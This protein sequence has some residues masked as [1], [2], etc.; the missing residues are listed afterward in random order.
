MRIETHY[1]ISLSL[2]YRTR[3]SKTKLRISVI[4]SSRTLPR[5]LALL[6]RLS[7]N[8]TRWISK[9]WLLLIWRSSCESMRPLNLHCNLTKS[10]CLKTY[11]FS[12][13]ISIWIREGCPHFTELY[14]RIIILGSLNCCNHG[15][16]TLWAEIRT[17]RK[18]GIIANGCSL[19]KNCSRKLKTSRFCRQGRRPPDQR[20]MSLSRTLTI[21]S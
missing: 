10:C 12:I 9:E 4:S 19:C 17:S 3:N 14:R 2:W 11:N 1:F 15:L 13:Q 7:W 16:A 18:L 20:G 8:W 6:L 5:G 21:R